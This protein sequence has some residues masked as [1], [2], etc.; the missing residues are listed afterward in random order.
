M[1]EGTT[2][3][4]D[5]PETKTPPNCIKINATECFPANILAP[6]EHASNWLR[7]NRGIPYN[8]A[9]AYI[10][11]YNFR[12]FVAN[13]ETVGDSITRAIGNTYRPLCSICFL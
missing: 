8:C 9:G 6:T 10:A 1:R 5:V 13:N 3:Y 7:S 11:E 12:M 4:M 2:I